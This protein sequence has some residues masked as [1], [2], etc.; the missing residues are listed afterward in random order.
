[1]Q[2]NS[3]LTR[4]SFIAT[5]LVAALAILGCGVST[6]S[7]LVSALEDISTVADIGGPAIAAL[8]PQA[9]TIL[10][11]VPGAVTAALD[12]VEGKTPASTAGTVAAQLTSI[13]TQ[14]QALVPNLNSADKLIVSAVLGALKAGIDLYTQKFPASTP[15]ASVQQQFRSAYAFG[16]VDSPN[17]ATAKVKKLG[18]KDK[19]AAKRARAH[20]ERL[21]AALAARV[22]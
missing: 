20:A 6:T 1:M 12:I 21:R 16:F 18:R 7:P 11:L 22:K 5:L 17:P 14:G 8:S 15:A 10:A 9:A 13:W 3:N 4:N 19:A 2:N